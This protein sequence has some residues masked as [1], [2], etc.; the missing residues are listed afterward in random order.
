MKTR[1]LIALL[2]LAHVAFA[3]TDAE[4]AAAQANNPL[5]NMKALNFHF[6]YITNLTNSDMKV[7]SANIRY[8]QPIGKFLIRASLPTWTYNS[9][10]TNSSLTGIGDL[11][12]FA[13]YLFSDASDPVQIGF[14]PNINIP[15]AS[16][17]STGALD[18]AILGA[19]NWQVGAAAVIFVAKNPQFQWGGLITYLNGVGEDSVN[20]YQDN[21]QLGALQPFY[22]FQL[23][24]GLYLR[25]APIWTFNLRDEAINMPL[26]IGMG[27]VVKMGNTVVNLFIEPQFSLYSKGANQANFQ[28]FGGINTQFLGG[29]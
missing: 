22:F 29:N 8:A 7:M 25:G 15:T 21:E 11:N 20:P 10:S 24:K 28:I 18:D 26:G 19:N 23:G 3:Q 12:F 9:P 16:G 13:T 17:T 14:G 5:A 1:I 4:K 6:N 27:K 2:F